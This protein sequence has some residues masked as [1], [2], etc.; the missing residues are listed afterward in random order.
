MS[1]NDVRWTPD[2]S[3]WLGKTPC[4]VYMLTSPWSATSPLN[5][6]VP[7]FCPVSLALYNESLGRG[8]DRY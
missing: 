5:P 3:S 2:F 7:G 6:A 4:E 1:E 8:W